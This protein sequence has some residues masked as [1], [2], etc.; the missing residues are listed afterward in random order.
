MKNLAGT[1]LLALV[2]ISS[3][4]F[5]YYQLTERNIDANYEMKFST[6][7]TDGTFSGLEGI[8]IFSPSDLETASLDVKLDA[9][10]IK[11]G[12]DKKDEH[13]NSEDWLD[14]KKYPEIRFTSSKFQKQDDKYL[15]YGTMKLHGVEK[16][17]QIPFSYNEESGEFNGS[18]VVNRSDYGVTGVGMKAKFV[19]EEIEISFNIPTSIKQ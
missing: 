7:S 10:S 5:A 11:T 13:A 1:L 16:D 4:G 6:R 3:F 2:T 15:V 19:G 18:F 17:V 9:S 8:V 12:N 14:T